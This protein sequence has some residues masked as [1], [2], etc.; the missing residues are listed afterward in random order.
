MYKHK[1][2]HTYS[3][4]V[5]LYIFILGGYM[6]SGSNYRKKRKKG[7]KEREGEKQPNWKK[8]PT[9]KQHYKCLFLK[10]WSMDVYAKKKKNGDACE[11]DDQNDGGFSGC[12]EINVVFLIRCLCL[13]LY[14]QVFCCYSY[15]YFR[16]KKNRAI[17]IMEEKEKLW[18]I[19][20]FI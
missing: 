19:Q 10:V 14:W 5:Y 4:S 16:G 8:L 12:G 17:S 13:N 15:S 7:K 3:W 2:T 9:I 11:N 20:K 6:G 1:P 18:K